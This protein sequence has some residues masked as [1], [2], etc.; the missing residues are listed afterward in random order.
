M[1]SFIV[2]CGG[3]SRRMGRDKG[4]MKIHGKPMIIHVI[5]TITPLA[6]EI[7]LV[8]RDENQV[9]SYKN[10]FKKFKSSENTDIKVLT[11]ILKDQGPLAG[12]LTGLINISSDKAMVIP[13]DS[14]FVS[15]QFINRIYETSEKLDYD[16][17][18]PKWSE[19]RLEPL[20]SI[21]KKNVHPT[22]QKLLHD[23][24]RDVKTLLTKLNVKYIDAESL[25]VSGMSFYNMNQMKDVLKFNDGDD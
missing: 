12:I 3:M 23:D 16:A 4:S 17:F 11:D 5:E 10:F 2:L 7:V 19:G 22:I 20:H 15:E 25:D 18:V 24:V 21:Y 13:C 8:L 6:D 14:P 9:E 1:K